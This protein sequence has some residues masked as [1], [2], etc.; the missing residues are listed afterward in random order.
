MA[1]YNRIKKIIEQAQREQ[2]RK[3]KVEKINFHTRARLRGVRVWSF[4]L[5]QEIMI[6]AN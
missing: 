3:R 6:N 1:L 5:N 4:Y 2:A